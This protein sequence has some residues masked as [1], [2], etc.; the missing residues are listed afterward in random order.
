M[1]N[2]VDENWL[3]GHTQRVAVKGSM[4]KWRLV[5]SGLVLI[6][7]QFNIYFNIFVSHM[8]CVIEC[9]FSKPV[10]NTKTCGVVN[11][12]EGRDAIQRDLDRFER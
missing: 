11:A 5:M 9:P 6:L 10:N 1:D 7:A 4:P 2:S 8:D 3:D 12:P